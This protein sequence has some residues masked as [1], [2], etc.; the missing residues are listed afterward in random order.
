MQEALSLSESLEVH[1][2]LSACLEETIIK[3]VNII[4]GEKDFQDRTR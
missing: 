1:Q 3:N 4:A 2:M